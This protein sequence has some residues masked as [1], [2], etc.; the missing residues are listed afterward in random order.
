MDN[1]PSFEE[2]IRALKGAAEALRSAAEVVMTEV[3][4]MEAAQSRFEA[5]K[6]ERR[7][8]ARASR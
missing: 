8:T 7:Q 6:G 1:K 4:H 3:V 2:R 5:R